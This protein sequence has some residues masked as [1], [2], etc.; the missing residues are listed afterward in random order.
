MADLFQTCPSLVIG[1]ADY[2]V[3]DMHGKVINIQGE[4]EFRMA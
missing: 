1:G 4:R 2:E 3:G